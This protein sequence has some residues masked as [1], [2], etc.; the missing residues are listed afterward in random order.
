[1]PTPCARKLRIAGVSSSCDSMRMPAAR[2]AG[3]ERA[4]E[5]G[6]SWLRARTTLDQAN[7]KPRSKPVRSDHARLCGLARLA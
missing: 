1:M 4:I 6:T 7:R 3:P 5:A 2:A